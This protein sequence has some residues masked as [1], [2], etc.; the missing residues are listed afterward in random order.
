MTFQPEMMD[1]HVGGKVESR[2]CARVIYGQH[3]EVLSREPMLREGETP[4]HYM[5]GR[6][7][8]IKD[9]NRV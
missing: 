1:V 5:D 7:Q 6:V 9:H 2:Q 8:I 4:L 3:G